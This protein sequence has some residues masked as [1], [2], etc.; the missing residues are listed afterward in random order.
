MEHHNQLQ[1]AETLKW[2]RPLV[3]YG[4]LVFFFITYLL[5]GLFYATGAI[6]LATFVALALSYFIERRLPTMPL[7][8]AVIVIVFGGLTLGLQDETFIKMKP[9]I[10]QLIFGVILLVGLS[11]NKLFLKKL[12]GSSLQM[13]NAGWSIL[14]RRFSFF[15]FSMAALNEVIWR[16]QSTDLWVNFKVF[17]IFGLTV[18]FLISQIGLL[19]QHLVEKK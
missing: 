10:I 5:A 16:T 13:D 6:I 17:G 15:F 4:P 11:T 18:L 2:V 1:K 8:T 7:I 9:T 14:T 12:M 19:K 3:E